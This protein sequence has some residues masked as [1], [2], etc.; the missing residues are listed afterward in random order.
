M[1]LREILHIEIWSKKTT[2]RIFSILGLVVGTLLIGFV[3]WFEVERHWLTKGEQKVASSAL[4][5]IDAL[6]DANSLSDEEFFRRE[7]AIEA[8]VVDADRAALTSRDKAISSGVGLCLLNVES[9]RM[10]LIQQ[11]LIQEG[12][13]KM[14]PE[15][16][17]RDRQ[18]KAR[19]DEIVRGICAAVHSQLD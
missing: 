5:Q 12:R 4:R 19:A 9:E 13:I 6:N 8:S 11:R 10:D 15:D 2:R 16:Q 18:T 14:M 7:N 17:G 3:V 1:T